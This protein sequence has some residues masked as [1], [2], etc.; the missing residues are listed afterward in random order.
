MEKVSYKKLFK[1]LI[2]RNLKKTE[3]AA[4]AGISQNTLAKMG[5]G[6]YISMEMLVRVCKYLDCSF[7]DV[8]EIIK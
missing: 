6:Q 3:F 1:M 5:K 8:V 2:D 4:N 7:D